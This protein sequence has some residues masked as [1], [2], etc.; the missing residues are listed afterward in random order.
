MVRKVRPPMDEIL[1]K[2]LRKKDDNITLFDA[3]MSVVKEDNLD[4]EEIASVIKK[5]KPF[6]LVLEQE[7]S[8]RGR[9][10]EKPK[11]EKNLNE[12]FN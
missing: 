4:I 7:C 5:N 11:P 3:V 6:L 8:T 10:K 9:L 2:I 12:M 1:E